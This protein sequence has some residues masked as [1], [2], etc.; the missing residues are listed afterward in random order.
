[1]PGTFPAPHPDELFY[2][3]CARF[4]D[5]V[6]YKNKLFVGFELFGDRKVGAAIDLPCH[7]GFLVKNL[8]GR[9]RWTVSK[10][11][12][13]H[14]L[15]PYFRTFLTPDRVKRVQECMKGH[16]SLAAKIVSGSAA[17]RIRTPDWIRFCPRCAERD[18]K[19]FDEYYWHRL[20]QAPGVEVCP[21]HNLFLNNSVARIRNRD[22]NHDFV[23]AER[24]ITDITAR[25]L[26]TS[27][28][29]H[30]VL[31]RIA[32]DTAWLL[33]QKGFAPGLEDLRQRYARLLFDR[34]LASY[35]GWVWSRKLIRALESYYTSELLGHLQCGIEDNNQSSWPS[36]IVKD[37]KRGKFH[38]PLQHLLLIQML[39]LSAEAFFELLTEYK[40]L[41]NGPWP[42]LNP[43]CAK[44]GKAII[45]QCR[46]LMSY[47]YGNRIPVGVFECD[48]GFI[49]YRKGPDTSPGTVSRFDRVKAYGPVWE[50]ALRDC[51]NDSTKTLED[52]AL[53]LCGS[54]STERIKIEAERLGLPFPRKA[55]N[56]KAAVRY[57]KR[58]ASV[59]VPPQPRVS[60]QATVREYRQRWREALKQNHGLSRTQLREKCGKLYKWLSQND[61]TW[62]RN[63]LP[64]PRDHHFDWASLDV[65]L[66]KKVRES[67]ER[68]RQSTIPKRITVHS[69]G[70][71]T[72][73]YDY[74][75]KNLANLPLTSAAIEEVVETVID[76]AKRKLTAA[77]ELLKKEA[78]LPGRFDLLRRAKIHHSLWEKL[79]LITATDTA[80]QSAKEMSPSILTF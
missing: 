5:L 37:L 32:Q 57:K 1:M 71:E 80:L 73:S 45:T 18:K 19:E 62:L 28:R 52:I 74:L 43:S 47:Q 78:I 29:N 50:A 26:D 70:R 36:V 65:E 51:W 76:F 7:L 58:S 10:I 4:Q 33:D 46:I 8:P 68:H 25:P 17:S 6:Q 24:A 35:G 16:D 75:R 3:I 41:G 79:D 38:H 44:Y 61:G 27:N 49:Y 20:H 77:A 64:P 34:G 21:T 11:I 23:S 69:I 15:F 31:L 14:T 42:C 9:H 12:E 40:P 48:C 39:G 72:D 60:F 67:A 54:K 13:E 30:Q 59:K 56:F 55:G 66:S 22:N 53:Y 63:H 2:S